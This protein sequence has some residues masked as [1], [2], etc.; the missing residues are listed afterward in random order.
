M[1]LKEYVRLGLNHHL[2]YAD[3]IKDSAEHFRTL[4]VV[5]SEPR[6]DIIDMWYPWDIKDQVLRAIKDSGKT[7]YYNM[8]NGSAGCSR[9]TNEKQR[10][11]D[12]TCSP[13]H[14]AVWQRE[15]AVSRSFHTD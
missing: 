1:K 14:I 9:A 4:Q 3:V 5:L 10:S 8:G 11:P 6:L 7:I 13:C 15:N 2:L 12:V